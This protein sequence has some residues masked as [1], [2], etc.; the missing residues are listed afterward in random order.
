M[1]SMLPLQADLV[2]PVRGQDQ[3]GYAAAE[4]RLAENVEQAGCR[5]HVPLDHR[6]IVPR[7]EP[8]QGGGDADSGDDPVGIAHAG[9]PRE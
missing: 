5:H 9:L 8:A 2:A 4:Y 1:A 7:T 6:E 3:A